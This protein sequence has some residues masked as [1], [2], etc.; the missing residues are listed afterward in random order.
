MP[1]GVH[2]MGDLSGLDIMKHVTKNFLDAYGERCYVSPIVDLMMNS[3]RLGQKTGVGYYKYKGR[4]GV[5]DEKGLLPLLTKAREG[6]PTITVTDQEI[7]EMVMYPVVNESCRVLAEG[8]V[9][10]ASDID[11]VSITGYGFPAHK[12]GIM[13]W[14]QHQGLKNV[15]AK[16]ASFSQKYPEARNFFAPCAKLKELAA[17]E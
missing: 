11:V 16:L 17:N 13:H 14:A 4:K 8:M 3:K 1:M 2:E 12:G 9:I 15:S 6:K 5:P 7:A 10:R